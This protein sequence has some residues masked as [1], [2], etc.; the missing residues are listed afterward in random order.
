MFAY[1]EPARRFY[2]RITSAYRL[3]KLF[4]AQHQRVVA[5]ILISIQFSSFWCSDNTTPCALSFRGGRGVG[6]TYSY[7]K[8]VRSSCC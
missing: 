1:A 6:T 2:E 7:A 3:A 4:R 8:D 5:L